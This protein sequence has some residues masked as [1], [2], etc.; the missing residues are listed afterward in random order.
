MVCSVFSCTLVAIAVGLAPDFGPPTT[1][2]G[3]WAFAI[4]DFNRDGKQDIAVLAGDSIKT[5]LGV[6]DG[7]FQAPIASSVGE[8]PADSSLDVGDF[9]A[10]GIPDLVTQI[11]ETGDNWTSRRPRLLLGVGDGTFQPAAFISSGGHTLYITVGDLNGDQASDLVVTIY[12]SWGDWWWYVDVVAW[13]SDG[14]GGFTSSQFWDINLQVDSWVP[15][16]VLIADFNNDGVMDWAL[17]LVGPGYRLRFYLGNGD[18][19]Y[20]PSDDQPYEDPNYNPYDL[21]RTLYFSGDFNNDGPTDVA[22]GST[23]FMGR[24]DGTFQPGATLSTGEATAD[25]DGD[26]NLDIAGTSYESPHVIVNLGRGDGTFGPPRTT[27]TYTDR[28]KT[29]DFNGDGRPDVAAGYGNSL[30]ILLNDGNWTG[31]PPLPVITIGNDTA[32][33]GDAGTTNANFRVRLSFTASAPVSVQYSTSPGPVAPAATPG[34]DYQETTGVLTFA[35]GEIEKTISIPVIGDLLTEPLYEHFSVNLSNP[36]NATIANAQ[37]LCAIYSE[38]NPPFISVSNVSKAE[39]NKGNTKFTFEVTL[40]SPI[41]QQ[42]S[43]SYRTVDGSAT[44]ADGDYSGANGTLNFAPGERTKTITI[45]VRGDRKREA[46]EV[47]YMDLFSPSANASLGQS[48]GTGTIFN[49]D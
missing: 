48:R 9:N 13:L 11:V 43:V 10:D 49:D 3:G 17:Q 47:F 27:F 41:Y 38:E 16:R 45:Q 36:S 5:L 22:T 46:D 2:F 32:T 6:G 39:G 25:F 12:D 21:T 18:G 44:T 4:A 34:V 40:S 28:I 20:A 42:V 23:L 26:G 33:E 29:A 7:T 24:G 31:T 19:T 8:L 35:P 15:G 30:T 37:G 1:Y 14:Q